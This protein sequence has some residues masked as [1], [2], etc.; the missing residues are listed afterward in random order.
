MLMKTLGCLTG[1]VLVAGCALP[2]K[3]IDEN[4]MLAFDEAVASIGCAL[5]TEPDYLPV[6]LQTGLTREEVQKIAAYRV[7]SKQGVQLEDGTFRLVTGP[8]TPAAVA[9]ATAPA[10]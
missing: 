8:C 9:P 1:L 10:L 4:D 2:P 3:G 7:T 5:R 6:E